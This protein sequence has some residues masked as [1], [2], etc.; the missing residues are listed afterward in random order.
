M[1]LP[2]QLFGTLEETLLCLL[3]EDLDAIRVQYEEGQWWFV[4]SS[5]TKLLQQQ[6]PDGI[7]LALARRFC[8]KWR[9]IPQL[10]GDPGTEFLFI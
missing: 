2:G 10:Q 8:Y 4:V 3:V 9:T 7:L 6:P 1:L 5:V